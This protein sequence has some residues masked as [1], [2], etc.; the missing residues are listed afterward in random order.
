MAGEPTPPNNGEVRRENRRLQDQYLET[1]FDHIEEKLDG[2]SEGLEAAR[3]DR[4]ELFGRSDQMGREIAV[5]Q[6]QTSNNTKAIEKNA[7]SI[8]TLRKVVYGLSSLA[9][10]VGAL[11]KLLA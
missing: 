4:K 2:I 6:T 9:V 10:V 11:V 1:K 3:K 5:A 8:S 7:G